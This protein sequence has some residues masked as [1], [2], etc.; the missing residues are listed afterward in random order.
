MTSPLLVCLPLS[1]KSLQ[2]PCPVSPSALAGLS[3]AG[4][5]CGGAAHAAEIQAGSLGRPEGTALFSRNV[6]YPTLTRTLPA[7]LLS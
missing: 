2:H 5:C 3:S 1:P 7:P 6:K 4:P